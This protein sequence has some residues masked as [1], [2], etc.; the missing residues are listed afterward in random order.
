MYDICSKLTIMKLGYIIDVALVS[1]LLNL[2]KFKILLWC[3]HCS[4]RKCKYRL[5]KLCYVSNCIFD[6]LHCQFSTMFLRQNVTNMKFIE[7][8]QPCSWEIALGTISPV[9]FCK[10]SII[11]GE[12]LFSRISRQLLLTLFLPF[13]SA[14]LHMRAMLG[15]GPL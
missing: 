13:L 12:K 9:F 10:I 3:F 2:N 15:H 5:G 6:C 4:F 8:L 7:K 11:F 1:Q 14:A